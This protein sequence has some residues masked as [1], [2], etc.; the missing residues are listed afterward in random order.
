MPIRPTKNGKFHG[1][2]V[3]NLRKKRDRTMKNTE[4]TQRV[5]LL[6]NRINS[7]LPTPR[8]NINKLPS[9]G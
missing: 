4:R 6:P 5:M 9:G 8:P 7:R 3:R 1:K 2:A